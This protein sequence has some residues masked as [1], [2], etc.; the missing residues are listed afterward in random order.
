[1][2]NPVNNIGAMSDQRSRPTLAVMIT[3]VA[4]CVC[5]QAAFWCQLI[6]DYDITFW[7]FIAG[8]SQYAIF[9]RV[10]ARA[11]STAIG[12][13]WL[14]TYLIVGACLALITKRVAVVRRHPWSAAFT[15]WLFIEVAQV[16]LALE[17]ARRHVIAIE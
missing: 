16:A 13:L 17:L 6:F 15:M 4:W 7:I 8:Y 14:L 2:A 9:H 11:P 1:M 10:L 12:V 5:L 3:A